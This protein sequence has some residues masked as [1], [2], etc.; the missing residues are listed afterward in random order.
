MNTPDISIDQLRRIH[1]L[2]NPIQTYAWGSLT[3]IPQLLGTSSPAP[4]PQA[5]LWMGAHTKAPSRFQINDCWITL[6]DAIAQHSELFLGTWVA[7]RFQNHLP[8]LFKVLAATKALSIQA[9][10][11]R[12]AA[13][14]GYERENAQGIPLN[15]AQRNFKDPN[16]KPECLCALT[17]FWALCGFRSADV[18]SKRLAR[19]CPNS[20]A[21]VIGKLTL[22]P[23]EKGL[24]HFFLAMLGLDPEDQKIAVTEA[25]TQARLRAHFDPVCRWIIRLHEQ[26]P[27]D[28][29]VLS[30]AILNLVCLKPGEALY[31]P[32]GELHAYLEGTAMEVM[33]N[34]D[35]VI[36]GG[37]TPKHVDVQELQQVLN[38]EERPLKIIQPV[39]R[40]VAE[41]VY[42]TPAEEFELSRIRVSEE[43]HYE[44]PSV[45][46]PEILLCVEGRSIIQDTGGGQDLALDKGRA[47]IVP[48]A[49]NAYR[50]SGKAKLYKVSVPL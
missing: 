6:I 39:E 22:R 32:E 12:A 7:N 14:K 37:L 5:E 19:L 20:L 31:L 15:D 10:P 42:V 8:Y 16:H 34:S 41:V 45:R 50:I 27:D 24:K 48:A 29:G 46:S 33:A 28:I 44:N 36:R 40:S 1:V 2:Q 25:V 18:I 13:V 47:V 9:H 4:Q 11:D 30:P 26:Y 43:L 17:S 35:N 49:V 3:A 21:N 38:F 23:G